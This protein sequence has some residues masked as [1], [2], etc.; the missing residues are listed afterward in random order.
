MTVAEQIT[1][2]L[3]PL[4]ID[5]LAVP[6]DA[7]ALTREGRS[8]SKAAIELYN[9]QKKR[10][11]LMQEYNEKAGALAP[12]IEEIVRL[13]DRINQIVIELAQG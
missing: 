7:Q 1:Q 10:Q 9:L 2:E 12:T 8:Y 6:K 13:H 4:P 5:V 11:I 3:P